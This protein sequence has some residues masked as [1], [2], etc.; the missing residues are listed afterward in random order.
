MV[1][2]EEECNWSEAEVSKAHAS[3]LFPTCGSGDS[4]VLPHSFLH[5]AMFPRMIIIMDQTS[6]TVSMPPIRH[7]LC[8]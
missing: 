4:E 5:V 7:F 8:Q 3:P 2:L 1:L 6:G